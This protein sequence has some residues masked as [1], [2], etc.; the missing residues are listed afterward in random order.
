MYLSVP[1]ENTMEYISATE[2][3]PL[4]SKCYVKVCYVSQ[5]PNR[6]GTV[7]TREVAEEM[8]KKLPGS[9][10]VG[11]YNEATEDFEG[12]NRELNI[13]G[14]QMK[15]VDVTRPYGFVPTDAKVW[16]QK[17][18]DNGITREYLVTECYIW[19][20]AYPESQRVLEKGNNQSMELSE[21][22]QDGFWTKDINSGTPLFIYNEALIEKLCILG[23]DVEPCFEGAQFVKQ[24]SW[25]EFDDFRT[26]MFSMIEN[27]QQTLQ[28]GGSQS[29]METN[30][31]VVVEQQIGELDNGDVFTLETAPGVTSSSIDGSDNIAEYAKLK[32]QYEELER[33]YSTLKDEKGILESEILTLR[34][35]KAE[36]ERK[37]KQ[38]MIDSFYMLTDE[39]KKDVIENIDTY[40]LSDIEAKLS[41][42]YVRS[43]VDFNANNNNN[44]NGCAEDGPTGLFN[45][46]VSVDTAPDWVKAVR[47]T[48]NKN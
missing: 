25:Q 8:G 43:N 48:A 47:E 29:S 10:V 42:A 2:I 9:P 45:L 17:F 44:N 26:K 30:N 6:N 38:E 12:H 20:G 11:Y 19:T 33:E 40:S 23:E 15:I 41:I 22:I 27:I 31:N 28:E 5:E 16:F 1:I 3:S 24:F 14:N 32:K 34:E 7:I 46:E 4:I 36:V 18:D 35:F 21:N 13:G 37:N 39:D